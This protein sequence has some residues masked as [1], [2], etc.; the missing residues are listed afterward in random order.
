MHVHAGGARTF[1][2]VGWGWA[3]V[4]LILKVSGYEYYRAFVVN[5]LSS[6]GDV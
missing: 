1:E 3:G 2:R 4:D 5:E 6:V